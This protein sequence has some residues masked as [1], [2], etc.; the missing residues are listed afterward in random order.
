M[1]TLSMSSEDE[2]WTNKQSLRYE[3]IAISFGGPSNHAN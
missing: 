3:N 1:R 2:Q